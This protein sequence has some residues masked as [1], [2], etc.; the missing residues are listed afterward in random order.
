MPVFQTKQILKICIDSLFKT[1][2]YYTE[3]IIINDGCK[4]D[5]EQFIEKSMIS[6]SL[7]KFKYI[8]HNESFGCPKSINQALQFINE[9]S[10]VIF[11]D[12][13]VIFKG[14]WQDEVINTLEDKSIGAVGGVLLYPQTSGIQCCGISYSNK[15]ARHI[16]LNNRLENL[17]LDKLM[18]VQA[19]VFAFLATRGSV[20][21]ETGNIDEG[22]F[23]GY[24][25]IDYQFR[26]KNNGYKIVTNTD[27]V[28]YHFEKSNG[29]HRQFSRK[30]NLGLFWSKNNKYITND[31]EKY[32]IKQLPKN[33]C[34]YILVNMCEAKI[35]AQ[36]IIETLNN[37]Y[38]IKKI[39]DYS[40]LCSIQEKIILPELLSSEAYSYP[41]SYIFLCDNFV[42]LC[43]NYYWFS[44]RNNFNNNDI[45]LDLYGNAIYP[46]KIPFWPGNKIR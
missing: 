46:I 26:I 3:I 8:N 7:I 25:D 21:K 36:L 33:S 27:I 20:I 12:S 37:F 31:L 1:I 28:L 19:T 44:I 4:F 14:N 41:L 34:D 32:L 2:K 16:Y 5:V 9:S 24:E 18:E 35:D 40:N 30:Q 15:L 10:Y 23:N 45:I 13:D 11:A 17:N 22:Y 42:E 38:S 29:V 6:N 39:I 43:E